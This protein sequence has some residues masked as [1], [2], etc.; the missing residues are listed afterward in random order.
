MKGRLRRPHPNWVI[1]AVPTPAT[2]R[3]P[4]G[5]YTFNLRVGRWMRSHLGPQHVTASIR[6]TPAIAVSAVKEIGG[7]PHQFH[8]QGGRYSSA[9]SPSIGLVDPTLERNG[10]TDLDLNELGPLDHL[11]VEFPPG[12]PPYTR[13]AI[14][15]SPIERTAAGGPTPHSG[16][17]RDLP[18]PRSAGQLVAT[19]GKTASIE[20]ESHDSGL[21]GQS[22]HPSGGLSQGCRRPDLGRRAAGGRACPE[23]EGSSRSW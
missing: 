7:R 20:V 8:P 17:A 15:G 2:A 5:T 23:A 19:A 12:V 10:V 14:F 16:L 6:K 3:F 1:R 21:T 22:A 9:R 13:P 4:E 11:V 18:A